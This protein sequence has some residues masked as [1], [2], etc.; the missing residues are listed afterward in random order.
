[1]APEIAV[2]HRGRIVE[3]A[4]RDELFAHPREEYTRTLIDAIPRVPAR[5]AA[6]EAREATS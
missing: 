3:Q 6:P 5:A 4:S 1:M 2:M